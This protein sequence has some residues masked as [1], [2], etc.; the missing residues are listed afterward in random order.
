MAERLNLNSVVDGLMLMQ[1][2]TSVNE[3]VSVIRAIRELRKTQLPTAYLDGIQDELLAMLGQHYPKRAQ[4]SVYL[5]FHG[6]EGRASHL[7]IGVARNVRKRLASLQTGSPLP[8]LW[9]WSAPFNGRQ[10]AF[11]VES[12]LLSI[13]EGN[14]TSGEWSSVGSITEPAAEKLVESL[15]DAAA[16]LAGH[17]VFERV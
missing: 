12:K 10:L 2:C 17:A 5:T 6:S 8:R 14:R 3:A 13:M 9:T 16:A 11:K 4:V 1:D 7:K 15:S